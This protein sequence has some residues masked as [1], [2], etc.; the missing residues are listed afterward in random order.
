M[1]TY[2]VKK[3]LFGSSVQGIQ[4]RLR[5]GDVVE[6][7]EDTHEV[8]ALQLNGVS[9]RPVAGARPALRGA[10]TLFGEVRIE[11]LEIQGYV[12]ARG[13]GT[14]AVLSRCRVH[15]AT[16]NHVVEV[17]S[18]AHVHVSDC[19]LSTVA[20][21]HAAIK[22]A[23]AAVRISGL[24]WDQQ[25]PSNIVYL[26]RASG[27]IEDC[28][29]SRCAEPAVC[30]AEAGAA[31]QLE[32]T[33]V[34]DCE[35]NAVWVYD[36]ARAVL[37]NCELWSCGQCAV[38]CRQGS[39][40]LAGCRLHH[41]KKGDIWIYDGAN[42]GITDCEMW[43]TTGGAGACGAGAKTLLKLT[44]T[45]VH[46]MAC[47]VYVKTGARAVVTECEF[48]GAA[49]NAALYAESEAT[50]LELLNVRVR[51]CSREALMAVDGAKVTTWDCDFRSCA[52]S[53]VWGRASTVLLNRSRLGDSASNG[54]GVHANAK[55]EIIECEFSGFTG[56]PALWVGEEGA[57]LQMTRTKVHDCTC[58]VAVCA[59]NSG[60]ITASDCEIWGVGDGA[61]ATKSATL[62]LASVKIRQCSGRAA[63]AHEGG[64][65]DLANCDFSETPGQTVEVL[66]G[67]ARITGCRVQKTGVWVH[68]GGRGEVGDCDFSD[69]GEHAALA[70]SDSG[71]V[72]TAAQV[73]VRDCIGF[74]VFATGKGR[75]TISASEFTRTQKVAVYATKAAEIQLTDCRI[76]ECK[77]GIAVGTGATVRIGGSQAQGIT[78]AAVGWAAG[79]GAS[80]HWTGGR[81]SDCS[82]GAFGAT[83]GATVTVSDVEVA[84]VEKSVFFGQAGSMKVARTKVRDGVSNGVFVR[85]GGVVELVECE[86]SSFLNEGFPVLL[87]VSAKLTAN[88]VRVH[89]VMSRCIESGDGGVA[90]FSYCELDGTARGVAGT[91]DGRVLLQ[92][93][94]LSGKSQEEAF[95]GGGIE[96]RH[97]TLNGEL[98]PALPALAV[99]S[100][101]APDP[102]APAPVLPSAAALSPSAAVARLDE[103][104]GLA[105]VKREISNLASVAAI[106]K[107]RRE[108]GLPVPPTTLHLVFTGNPGTGKTTVARIVGEIYADLG[109]L[110]KGH[111][112][113]VERRNM[114]GEYIGHTA[115]KTAAVIEKALDGVLFIDEAYTLAGKNG[116]DF[117][118]EAVDTLLKAMEDK[119]DRL[120]VIVA[121]YTDPMRRFI[122]SN[123]GLRSRFTRYIDFPDYAPEEL[124]QI[125]LAM[126]AKAQYTLE[127]EAREKLTKSIA[128]IYRTRDEHFGNARDMRQLFEKITEAQSLRLAS[129]GLTALNEL[130]TIHVTDVPSQYKESAADVDALLG[131]L[132]SLIGLSAVKTEI[133]K[134]VDLVRLNQR[135]VAEGGEPVP[136]SLHMAFLGNPG[137]GKTTVARM[138]GRILAGLG[139]L[140][141]GHMVETDRSGL[142]AGY[143][144]QT[145]IKTKEAV[146][147]ALD[148]VL[149]VDEAYSLTSDSGQ[150]FGREAVDSLL[151]EM[152]DK[153]ERL[154]VV[155]AGYTG[156]MEC[157][158]ASN[159]GLQSRFTRM[160]SFADYTREELQAIFEKLC[161]D[162]DLTL[163][164][165]AGEPLGRLLERRCAQ[166]DE[167]FGNARMVRTLFETCLEN[168][169][170]RLQLEPAESIRVLASRDI[171]NE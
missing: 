99:V 104:I 42:A 71:S 96:L 160:L 148:G 58:T 28:D 166:R 92:H 89:D 101:A 32:R 136:V 16:Q 165:D 52:S 145:A 23:E 114:V 26:R 129:G 49:G 73:R 38:E 112:I 68:G 140:R 154:V 168:Q 4:N 143:I 116:N 8:G 91:A 43:G 158:L 55:V 94:R 54:V 21:G 57:S 65:L 59:T 56:D 22:A 25:I 11:G 39:L 70:V 66:N 60:A 144:G 83:D 163:S 88:A 53:A 76:E 149:F 137:T 48:S 121:G 86:F 45:K 93:C 79:E 135:R 124:E 33:R 107:K 5:P 46:D 152:E 161:R 14:K 155:V 85:D 19:Q 126:F 115:P 74:A 29:F 24:V 134:L 35:T 133:R 67:A 75:A 62:A 6:F 47:G 122:E 3:G 117:G 111:V 162:R 30:V 128:E 169:A 50:S 20:T 120:A 146:A 63:M 31:A 1:A 167:S 118:P 7:G 108:H 109:L 15:T 157:F 10:L 34:H 141:K 87:C 125:L 123:P 105:Q 132:D 106:Q 84:R 78:E 171:P 82:N 138:L 110:A 159:P 103:L 151:K 98:L 131:E 51:D 2:T 80:L 69:I 95:F 90:E 81:V 17:S 77:G 156:P 72:L 150:D 147:S 37:T 130:Q 9:L 119:R 102:A 13:A 142:V 36:G 170:R 64:R 18:G 127:P 113:E 139:L 164:P 41:G 12:A 100:E 40:R 153:R 44:R 61:W 27:L 97:S